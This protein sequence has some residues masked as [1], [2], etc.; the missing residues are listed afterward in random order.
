MKINKEKDRGKANYGWL[1]ANYSFSF[2]NYF[3]PNKM[4][5]E[6]LLVINEDFIQPNKGFPTHSHK[7]MEILTIVLSGKLAHKDSMGNIE[8]LSPKKI[9][10]M[11][12]GTGI[13]HSE[14]N[15]S[16]T[17]KLNLL[18]IWIEPN[19][20]NKHPEYNEKD[21]DPY[22]EG[23][24]LLVSNDGK[25]NSIKFYQNVD[26]YYNFYKQDSKLN[27]DLKTKLYI[28]IIKGSIEI[29]NNV[30]EYGDS[31]ELEQNEIINLQFL[32]DSQFIIFS[33]I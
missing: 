23:S 8:F 33:F 2:A 14:F 31:I 28:H 16:N 9:Q 20:Q 17:H 21:F 25:D 12:A 10:R 30:V 32:K 27:L 13:T 7:N 22:K 4:G 26:I 24:Q 11:Y 18:Q 29:D 6:S 3:N 1:K 5:F 15:N 19:I